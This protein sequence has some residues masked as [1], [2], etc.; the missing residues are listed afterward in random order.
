MAM[1]LQISCKKKVFS[2]NLNLLFNLI[3]ESKSVT[4]KIKLIIVRSSRLDVV[5]NGKTKKI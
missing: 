3:M 5:I 2:W 1:I 4:L